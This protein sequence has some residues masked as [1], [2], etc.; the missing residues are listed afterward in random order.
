MHMKTNNYDFGA[1]AYEAPVFSVIQFSADGV[2][3]VSNGGNAGEF[4]EEEW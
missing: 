4:E 1:S 2:L 3:C